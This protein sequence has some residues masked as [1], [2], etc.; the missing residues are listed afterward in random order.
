MSKMIVVQL[1]PRHIGDHSSIFN[2]PPFLPHTAKSNVV[3]SSRLTPH[4]SLFTSLSRS[5]YRRKMSETKSILLFGATGYIGKHITH[6]LLSSGSFPNIAI[7]TSPSTA[8][9]K[10]AEIQL[11]KDRGVRVIVGDAE[12]EEDLKKAYTGMSTLFFFVV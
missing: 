12:N 2:T 9:S 10:A 3:S 5:L 4:C 7:F 1:K 11:L 6:S 8:E